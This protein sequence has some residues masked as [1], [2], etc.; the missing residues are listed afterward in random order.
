M[1]DRVLKAL[2]VLFLALAIGAV[3]GSVQAT[4]RANLIR[5]PSAL[6]AVGN[7]EVWLSVDRELWRIAPDGALRDTRPIEATGLPGVPAN[8]VRGPGGTVVASVRD[9][10]TLYFVDAA[11]ARMVGRMT[12]QWPPE[13]SAHGARAIQFDFDPEGRVAISTGGGHAV[14][15]FDPQ[16]TFIARTPR[17]AY[18]F[19]NGLWWAREGLWTTDTNRFTLR[20]LDPQTLAERRTIE[21]GRSAGGS[22]LGPARGRTQTSVTSGGPAAALLRFENGM[23]DGAV[24]LVGADGRA[25]GLPYGDALQPLDLDWRSDELLVTD[26]LSSSILRWSAQGRALEPFCDAA[27]R[28]RLRALA[29][30]RREL[31]AQHTRWL[32]AAV[33]LL[34]L[35]LIAA[36]GAAAATRRRLPARP[37]D[38]SRLGTPRVGNWALMR[39]NFRANGWLLLYTLPALVLSFARPEWLSQSRV[40]NSV[41]LSIA[42]ASIIV[43]G[44]VGLVLHMR[45]L[46][47]LARQP[48]FEPMF[49]QH[50]MRRLRMHAA[51]VATA[52]EP[53]ERVLESFHLQPGMSWWV[54]TDRRMLSF[55]ATWSA[56]RLADAVPLSRV[57]SVATKRGQVVHRT[58]TLVSDKASWIEIALPEGKSITGSTGFAPLSGRVAKHLERLA[59]LQRALEPAS[60][61]AA[62]AG[63]RWRR[64]L[65][66]LVVPGAGHWLQGR[67]TEG[68]ILLAVWLALLFF[69]SGPMVWTLVE[70]YADVSRATA[71]I[72]A[73]AH[74][75]LGV[76][77][78]IDVWRIDGARVI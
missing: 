51:A 33:T 13:L 22:Y 14:A 66:S 8:L 65:L 18:E 50:A 3:F 55:K 2:A 21:L 42:A 68:T 16:G 17:G 75:A 24:A 47:R 36:G 78:A 60:T 19:T 41:W 64:A 59:G 52:L 58:W 74:G 71:L 56:L 27:L 77:A 57:K 15:L 25:A 30:D 35:G 34:L 32:V 70:P 28:A 4:S 45:R 23:V 76:L 44:G 9:D 63:Q 10:P 73:M 54:I 62:S 46:K 43:L 39:L 31:R 5:G 29:E 48:E 67:A 7:G 72:A 6:V 26:G 37:L 38:L 53:G 11:S 20:L 12:P 40:A 69:L 1:D 61:P 49:N